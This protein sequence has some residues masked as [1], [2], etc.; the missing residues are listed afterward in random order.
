MTFPTKVVLF[1]LVF[2]GAPSSSSLRGQTTENGPANEVFLVVTESKPKLVRQVVALPCFQSRLALKP[3]QTRSIKKIT[4]SM[5]KA[6]KTVRD[7]PYVVDF[8][9]GIPQKLP[10]EIINDKIDSIHREHINFITNELLPFQKTRHRQLV[11]W[12]GLSSGRLFGEYESHNDLDRIADISLTERE[13]LNSQIKKFEKELDDELKK[14]WVD[15]HKELRKL[16]STDNSK[17]F[18]QLLG[19]P[20]PIQL[21]PVP[22]KRR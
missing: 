1:L 13:R 7:Q 4:Q 3:N 10:S 17:N 18:D 6:I 14:L 12:Y 20:A 8:S 16:S 19:E 5:E 11:N 2:Y 21:R 9:H 15:Y 22:G